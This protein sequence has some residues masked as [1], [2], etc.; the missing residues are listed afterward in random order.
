MSVVVVATIHPTAEGREAVIDA[1]RHAVARVHAEDVGCELYALHE[2]ER[3][4]VM[5]EKWSSP[6]ALDEHSRSA[7]VAELE[8]VVEDKLTERTD[9]QVYAAVP[10]GVPQLGA[11]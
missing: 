2:N 8:A 11:L 5:V 3:R 1:F 10:S 6:E 7:A 9:V 4:L